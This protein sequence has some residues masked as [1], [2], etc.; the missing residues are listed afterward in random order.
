MLSQYVDV[1][2]CLA[3]AAVGLAL[4]LGIVWY[5]DNAVP[6]SKRTLINRLLSFQAGSFTIVTL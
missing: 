2:V 4:S 3:G 6:E 5:M 1:A